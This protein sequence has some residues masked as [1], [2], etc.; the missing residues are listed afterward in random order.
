M[1]IQINE[2]NLAEEE[3][4]KKNRVLRELAKQKKV[5][6]IND[7]NK[8]LGHSNEND[9]MVY[10]KSKDSYIFDKQFS[11]TPLSTAVFYPPSCSAYDLAYCKG[12][13]CVYAYGGISCTSA[14][15][16]GLKQ[17]FYRLEDGIWK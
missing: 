17:Y 13:D 4:R 16:E 3:N 11:I 12:N 10:F 2:E 8:N 7:E 6:M 14:L 1:Q 9:E 5:N 15:E